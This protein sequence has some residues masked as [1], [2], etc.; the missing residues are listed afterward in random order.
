MRQQKEK[1]S[2]REA[3]LSEAATAQENALRTKADN[4]IKLKSARSQ[5]ALLEDRSG[6]AVASQSG[7]VEAVAN[8]F[9]HDLSEFQSKHTW[10]LM[11]RA[12]DRCQA[13]LDEIKKSPAQVQIFNFQC[14]SEQMFSELQKVQL[15]F[16]RKQLFAN[17]CGEK[18]N[19]AGKDFIA[20]VNFFNGCVQTS[21]LE[22]SSNIS[23]GTI[24]YLQSYLEREKVARAEGSDPE[25]R[26]K[27]GLKIAWRALLDPTQ[28]YTAYWSLTI[29]IV[30]DLL[31]LLIALAGRTLQSQRW[32]DFEEFEKLVREIK[33]FNLEIT[34]YDQPDV[35]ALKKILSNLRL[36][37]GTK[38]AAFDLGG[39]GLA[40]DPNVTNFLNQL[41]LHHEAEQAPAQ[42][43]GIYNIWPDGYRRLL[44]WFRNA[45][46]S[47]DGGH[48]AY[49]SLGAQTIEM[50]ARPLVRKQ[51]ASPHASKGS[52]R[53]NSFLNDE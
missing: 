29:A 48:T 31:V 51:T 19:N 27:A 12:A 18:A 30:I 33:D 39:S 13:L 36:V 38:A 37:R 7:S 3:A 49:K 17:T 26:D 2:A 4:E 15:V 42:G 6:A 44:V 16:E 20:V 21:A 35:V 53:S 24:E 43:N 45:Q 41:V 11:L 52:W 14:R 9:Q 5:L 50:P 32:A 28:N 25:A 8:A 34:P 23:F 47:N 10:E 22:I 40:A 46:S 1:L